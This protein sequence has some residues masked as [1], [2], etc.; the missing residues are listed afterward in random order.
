MKRKRGKINKT[1][2]LTPK[3][4]TDGSTAKQK[5]P[6][7]SRLFF[8]LA[9]DLIIK[10]NYASFELKKQALSLYLLFTL[11]FALKTFGYG[12]RKTALPC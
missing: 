7:L 5:P 1:K 3:K 10:L 8:F 6:V 4:T 11:E 2:N 12:L 9:V